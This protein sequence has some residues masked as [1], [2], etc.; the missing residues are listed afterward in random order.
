MTVLTELRRCVCDL[1]KRLKLRNLKSFSPATL[2]NLQILSRIHY[3]VKFPFYQTKRLERGVNHPL[4]PSAEVREIEEMY[5]YSPLWAFMLCYHVNCT[6]Y[7]ELYYCSSDVK[8]LYFCRVNT[9]LYILTYVGL[10]PPPFPRQQ[11]IP[12]AFRNL[13]IMPHVRQEALRRKKRNADRLPRVKG[14]ALHGNLPCQVSQH[15]KEH[16]T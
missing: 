1:Y 10:P 2:E 3:R 9:A 11:V 12:K 4:P 16:V 6:F 5:L 15:V 14:R 8:N 13:D 7:P